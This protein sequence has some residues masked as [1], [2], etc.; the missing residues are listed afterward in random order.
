MT[1]SS[2]PG[3]HIPVN[4][5]LHVVTRMPMHTVSFIRTDRLS[6]EMFYVVLLINFKIKVSF[7]I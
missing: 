7:T 4:S 6:S 1:V 2:H 3:P 5:V